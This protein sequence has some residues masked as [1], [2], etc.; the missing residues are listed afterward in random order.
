MAFKE[1]K[2][3]LLNLLKKML[4]I[5]YFENKVWELLAKNIIKGASH[6]YIGEE[7]VAVGAISVLRK[8]DFITSTHR[9]H[10]HCLAKGGELKYMLAEVCGKSTGYCKGRGG[11]MHIADVTTGNLG[12]TGI[13]GSN[14]PIATGAGLSIKMRK[15]DQVVLCFFG[16]GATNNGI[17]HESLNLASLW[18]LPVVYI[19]ENNLYGMSVSVKRASAKKELY[20]KACAYDMPSEA[21][22]GMDVMKVREATE[23]AVERA[24]KGGGPTLLEART[25]RYKGH[26][27]SDPRVYRTKEEEKFWQEKDAIKNFSEKLMREKVATK[28]EIEQ[29]EKDVDREIE[30]AEKFALESPYPPVEE[31][32][33]DVYVHQ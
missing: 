7:A 1:S 4:Q 28:E 20:K 33:K 5:R 10:G 31:L 27:R 24:R 26:S 17:F 29:V 32:E 18:K 13:V 19:I 3:E 15:T 2:E 14:M 23:R 16:D 11:S 12:A 22:D 6:V 25:Y 9:G 21:V 8:D 30:E